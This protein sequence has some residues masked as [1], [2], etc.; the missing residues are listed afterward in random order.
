MKALACVRKAAARRS[1]GGHGQG[2]QRDAGWVEQTEEKGRVKRVAGAQTATDV[3]PG[4]P[5]AGE[6]DTGVRAGKEPI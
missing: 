5:A 3:N 4:L 6:P 2:E 1:H